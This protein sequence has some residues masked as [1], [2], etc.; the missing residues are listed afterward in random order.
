MRGHERIGSIGSPPGNGGSDVAPLAQL[1]VP[2]FLLS[3]A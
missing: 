1:G 3:L 2:I